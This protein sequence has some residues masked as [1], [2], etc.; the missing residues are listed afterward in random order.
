MMATIAETRATAETQYGLPE[1]T[2]AKNQTAQAYNQA[3]ANQ[4][5]EE[6]LLSALEKRDQ[7]AKEFGAK[8]SRLSSDLYNIA[9]DMRAR[10][11]DPNSSEYIEDP[12]KR[13]ALIAKKEARKRLELGDLRNL[14]AINIDTRQEVVGKV[15][16]A[17]AKSMAAAQAAYDMARNDWADKISLVQQAVDDAQTERSFAESQRQY[18]ESLAEQR[19]QF[20]ITESRLGSSGGGGL[21]EKDLIELNNDQTDRFN[22][23]VDDLKNR[24]M[25]KIKNDAGQEYTDWDTEGFK[26]A[27][28]TLRG[29]YPE[30]VLTDQDINNA[31]GIPGGWQ[32]L[33]DKSELSALQERKPSFTERLATSKWNPL[34][35]FR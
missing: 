2:T 3:V 15:V 11:A 9:P 34:N 25:I 24:Y 33:Q 16:A 28:W 19:R 30:D 26:Q 18:N 31:L 7:A 14:M 35:W 5:T 8:E 10:F 21:S 23:A 20:D 27:F 12:Y 17:A 1:A 13:E 29:A 4:P 32:Y 6:M 22:K